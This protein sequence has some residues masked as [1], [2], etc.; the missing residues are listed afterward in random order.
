MEGEQLLSLRSRQGSQGAG[1][2]RGSCRSAAA[3]HCCF[4]TSLL[5]RRSHSNPSQAGCAQTPGMPLLLP[6]ARPAGF[7]HAAFVFGCESQVNKGH[8]RNA[9]D[10]PVGALVSF[11]QKGFQYMEIEANL[12]EVRCAVHAGHAVHTALCTLRLAAGPW[13]CCSWRAAGSLLSATPFATRPP[14]AAGYPALRR[15]GR[16]CMGST[17]PSPRATS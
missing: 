1:G 8:H 15:R 17:R 3:R 11:I 12:N 13:A 6:P 9:K 10:V 5:H 14:T 4:L 7:T 2:G 16:M